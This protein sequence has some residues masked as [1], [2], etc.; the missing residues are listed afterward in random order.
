MEDEDAEE[1]ADEGLH[2]EE[3]SGLGG[4]DLGEAP[5]P[6]QGGGGGAESSAGGEGEPGFG[7]D[8]MDGWRTVH[9]GHAEGE[10]GGAGGGAPG[11]DGDGG[12]GGHEVLVEEHPGEGDGEGED[13][14]E[15]SGEGG[16]VG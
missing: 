11:A 10:H 3:D 8:V 6:E 9:D 2:V 7:R 4:G 1:G 13:D 16:A 15:V 5:V 14:E 12:V